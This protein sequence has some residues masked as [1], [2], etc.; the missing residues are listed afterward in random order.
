MCQSIT[1]C[2]ATDCAECFNRNPR[3]HSENCFSRRVEVVSNTLLSAGMK[4]V[5][6]KCYW[7]HLLLPG[8]AWAWF[9]S[10]G[11]IP[12]LNERLSVCLCGMEWEEAMWFSGFREMPS[13]PGAS[14]LLS[15]EYFFA[16][17]DV[18]ELNTLKRQDSYVNIV[19]VDYWDIIN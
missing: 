18:T 9:I 8:V 11:R 2:K 10:S 7:Y 6:G 15:F 19:D 3:W 5:N 12:L 16:S 13:Y 17:V 14:D 4:E 1:N